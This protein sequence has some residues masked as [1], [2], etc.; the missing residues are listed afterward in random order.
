M[1]ADS[2]QVPPQDMAVR[3][4]IAL[5]ALAL[6]IP[7]VYA[8]G[9]PETAQEWLERMRR[10]ARTLNYE[11]TFVYR[12]G[13]QLEA[14]R[15]VHR[16]DARGEK[17]RLVSLNG[18]PREVLRD[19][20]RVTCILPDNH[21]VVVDKIPRKGILPPAFRSAGARLQ[22]NYA[23][24]LGGEDRVA[25]RATRIVD[26]RPKDEYRYGSRLWLDK[27]TGLLLK[28]ELLDGQGASL[29]QFLYTSIRL[30]ESIPDEM[31]EPGTSG[32]G[33]TR[34]TRGGDDGD[35]P[36][37]S[38][39][40]VVEW[41]PT[42]FRMSERSTDPMPNRPEPVEHMLFSDGLASFSV[43][44]ERMGK[45]AEPF[46][47]HSQIGAVNAFGTMLGDYQATVVGEVPRL[48]VDRVGRA[49]RRK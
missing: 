4:V 47:G 36:E 20:E 41:L 1:P 27:A 49:I 19:K 16:S 7:A 2:R 14:M 34:V 11:G 10:A 35:E 40:W 38:T 33:Y 37:A 45:D 6:L 31:L 17:E 32:E 13:E 3:R 23:F 25:G 42:G 5:I 39:D 48:T 9:D 30:P 29:E 26:I 28:S 22:G 43:Y 44:L 24:S 18:V 8:S 46:S 21:S 15:I 12:Q